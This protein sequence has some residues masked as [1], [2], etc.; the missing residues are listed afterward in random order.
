MYALGRIGKVIVFSARRGPIYAQLLTGII[1]QTALPP[2]PAGGLFLAGG[3]RC[4]G[5]VCLRSWPDGW[6]FLHWHGR[7]PTRS[8]V[9]F[10]RS[11]YLTCP[12]SSVLESGFRKDQDHRATA[13]T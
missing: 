2:A 8:C 9:P 5:F 12:F 13:A 10:D 4:F 3:A 11:M 7:W 6:Y 1:R